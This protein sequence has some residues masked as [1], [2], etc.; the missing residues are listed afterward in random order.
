MR[1]IAAEWASKAEGDFAIVERK[2]RARRKPNY[3]GACFHAQQCAEKR[4]KARLCEDD[5]PFPK[6]HDLMA[7]LDL[8][9]LLEPSWGTYR[10]D[11]ALLSGFSVDYRCPGESADRET[12]MDARRR[13][14]VFRRTA[15]GALGLQTR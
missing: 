10:D 8:V 12:A 6:T 4:L 13:C 11:L 7:L 5:V 14:R 2:R 9:C 15:R 3:D 1:A